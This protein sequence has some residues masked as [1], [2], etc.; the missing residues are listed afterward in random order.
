MHCVIIA[1]GSGTR[2]WPKSRRDRP[3]QLLDFLN[4]KSLLTQ[5]TVRLEKYSRNEG[6][7]I[8]ASESLSQLMQQSDTQI[9]R[10]NYFIE[11]SPR[12][13]APAIALAAFILRKRFG[14]DAVMGVFPAD[15][16][17]GKDKQFYRALELAEKEAAAGTNLITLGIQP[18]YP[19]TGFG[20]V[21]F[22][23]N[24]ERD[25]HPVVRFTEKPDLET[26]KAF[27]EGGSHLWN[28]GMFVWRVDT[29]LDNLAEYLPA[30]SENLGSIADL[31][32]TPGFA[33]AL[34]EV[35]PVVDRIS[36]DYGILENAKSIYTIETRFDWNDLGSWRT[37]YEVLPKDKEGNVVK[38]DVTVLDS[39]NSL[40]VSEGHYTAVIGVEDLIVVTVAD[41]TIVLPRSQ[42]E[43]VPE[44]VQW[45]KSRKRQDLL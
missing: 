10:K 38:G 16:L 45:L 36:V 3:K 27:L 39:Q 5:T 2:F 44:I 32:D 25:I 33:A 41:A 43:R 6:S 7:Y 34:E 31:I 26:A 12:N 30:T 37:L 22:T 18:N 13:T 20:Y 35:W 4:G 11:P 15:H 17:I 1:G 29:F 8:V 40:V 9:P 23:R 42:S 21:Q 19:A 14:G 24:D 28:G